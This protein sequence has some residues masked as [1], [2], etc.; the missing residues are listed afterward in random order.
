MPP[1]R[2]LQ[3]IRNVARDPTLVPRYLTAKWRHLYWQHHAHRNRGV[4]SVEIHS[5]NGFFAQLTWC[6]WVFAYCAERSLIPHLVLTSTNYVNLER[7]PD[8]FCHFFEPVESAYV[9]RHVRTTVRIRTLGDL[10][11]P[12]SGPM[13]VERAARLARAYLAVCAE[14]RDAVDTFVRQHFAGTVVLG[15]HYRGTDK[16]REAP[17][18]LYEEVGRA[19]RA[20]LDEHPDVGCLF[21]ATDEAAFIDYMRGAFA[22]MRLSYADD[23]QSPSRDAVHR[24]SFGGDGDREGREALLAA[25]LLSRCDSVIR[26]A[27]TLSAWASIF[28]PQLPVTMLNRPYDHCVWF[29]DRE[30]VR[31]ARMWTGAGA[32]RG[33]IQDAPS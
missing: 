28:N 12:G 22:T 2:T 19:V 31:H 11:L 30:L 23:L 29:P 17:R 14:I 18:V 26:T 9:D 10:G 4:V 3:R 33:T 20:H 25:L 6:L 8:W 7:G 1:A 15:I 32:L 16:R 13:T 24:P 27:S 21:L 5:T